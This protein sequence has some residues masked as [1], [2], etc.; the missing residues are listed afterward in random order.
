RTRAPATNTGA[1]GPAS[2]C[3]GGPLT[4]KTKNR[5]KVGTNTA[6]SFTRYWNARTTVTE[7]IRP[8][9]APSRMQRTRQGTPDQY[10]KPVTTFHTRP[11][12]CRCG[13]MYT[14]LN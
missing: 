3:R 2:A 6:A 14:L 12:A 1:A 13:Y 8:V 9:S 10:G 4:R 7:R 11:A 5:A